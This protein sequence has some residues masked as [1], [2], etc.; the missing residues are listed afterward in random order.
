MPIITDDF[1]EKEFG[2]GCVKITPAHDYT[3]H[4]VGLRHQLEVINIMNLDGT[5]NDKCGEFSAS[6]GSGAGSTLG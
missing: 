6:P 4:E 3:D 5:L 2:T 1:V